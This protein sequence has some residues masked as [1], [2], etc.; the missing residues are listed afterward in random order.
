MR[1]SHLA[2]LL[3]QG[4][5]WIIICMFRLGCSLEELFGHVGETNAV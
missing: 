1:P 5:L 2:F 4:Y 3:N